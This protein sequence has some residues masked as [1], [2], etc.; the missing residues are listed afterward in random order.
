MFTLIILYIYMQ[1]FWNLFSIL[2]DLAVWFCNVGF[3]HDKHPVCNTRM[4]HTHK[5]THNTHTHTHIYVYIYI[6]ITDQTKSLPEDS[7]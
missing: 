4:T 1:M 6:S 3:R 2:D 5:H 7:S